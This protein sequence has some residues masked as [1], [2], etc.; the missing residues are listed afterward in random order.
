MKRANI[1]WLALFGAGLFALGFFAH[2]FLADRSDPAPP[3]Y[4]EQ[5]TQRLN[6]SE[7]QQEKIRKL[8]DEGDKR[9]Q[10]VLGN[11][12][13]EE[14]RRSMGNI[15]KDISDQIVELLEGDQKR[16]YLD[17]DAGNTLS[18]PLK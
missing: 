3:T 14:I 2:K 1:P 12:H 8:L 5:L 13:G 4:L 9:I 18:D 10:E 16:L 6:L 7:D 17:S 15:R 11:E